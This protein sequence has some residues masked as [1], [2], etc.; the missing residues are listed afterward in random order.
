MSE[1]Q[2]SW[3]RPVPELPV[4]D[5]ARAQRH[6]RDVFGFDVDWADPSASIGAV[7]RGVIAIFLRKTST[8]FRPVVHWVHVMNLDAMYAELV[9]SGAKVLEAPEVKPWGLRQFAVADIDGNLFYFHD[10][11][12]RNT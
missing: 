6:Y 3:G 4:A 7:S 5:V 12:R 1:P 10:G 9:S 2:S 8:P 11:T